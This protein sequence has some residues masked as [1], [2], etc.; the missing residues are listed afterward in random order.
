MFLECKSDVLSV[1]LV[2]LEKS[3]EGNGHNFVLL[4]GIYLGATKGNNSF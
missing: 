3:V 1:E 2:R 4:S